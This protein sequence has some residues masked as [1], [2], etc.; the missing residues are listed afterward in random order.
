MRTRALISAALLVPQA[1]HLRHAPL[2][3]LSECNSF[4]G[5]L[6]S[7]GIIGISR[8][9]L[10]AGARTLVA[11]LWPVDDD[12]TCELMQRFYSRLFKEAAGDAAVALQG[13]MVSMLRE[14]TSRARPRFS[15][16]QWAA[17]VVYGLASSNVKTDGGSMG[18]HEP[19]AAFSLETHAEEDDADE[20]AAAIALSLE[21]S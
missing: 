9:F 3:V 4:R 5:E 11:S 6:R 14:C 16:L 7:D 17:F 8:T 15:A 10:A 1:L 18:S 21:V 19:A 20:L 2:I 13:A 12:A